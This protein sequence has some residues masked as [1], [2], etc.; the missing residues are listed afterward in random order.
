MQSSF[1]VLVS[2]ILLGSIRRNQLDSAI[3]SQVGEKARKS[4]AFRR[5]FSPLSKNR[6]KDVDGKID[7]NET[8]V[9]VPGAR[10]NSRFTVRR[11]KSSEQIVD[12]VKL[13]TVVSQ[14]TKC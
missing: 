11:V 14:S 10:R 3:E 9:T 5:R 7:E 8:V 1:F 2:M 4:E 12:D 6:T 13:T